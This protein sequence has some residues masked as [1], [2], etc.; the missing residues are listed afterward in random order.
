VL[1]REGVL[2]CLAKVESFAEDALIADANDAVFILAVRADHT[3]I[4]QL[5]FHHNLLL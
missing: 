4:D 5:R 2:A 1:V 3:V